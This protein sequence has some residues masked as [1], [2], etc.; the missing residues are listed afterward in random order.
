MASP[1][2]LYELWR[3]KGGVMKKRLCPLWKNAKVGDKTVQPSGFYF[4]L[5]GDGVCEN[6]VLYG[7]LVRLTFHIPEIEF[8]SELSL[9]FSIIP[10]GFSL[11]ENSR[12]T[13]TVEV[14]CKD[15][16]ISFS[17]LTN[18]EREGGD[19][20]TSGFAF[21]IFTGPLT[22]YQKFITIRLSDI[23]SSLPKPYSKKIDFDLQ[24]EMEGIARRA[25]EWREKLAKTEFVE[26]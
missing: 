23:I 1:P 17:L 15:T 4:T 8:D 20:M 5:E 22:V 7:S 6:E 19:T 9:D 24:K 16:E 26:D 11:V 2:S 12:W 21:G 18:T 25:E 14:P 13:Q 3:D 10:Y